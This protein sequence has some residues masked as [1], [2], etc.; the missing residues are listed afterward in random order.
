MVNQ[1]FEGF[2]RITLTGVEALGY[3]G[4]LTSERENGQPFI[5]DVVLHAEIR[6]AGRTDDLARTVDYSEVADVI[7]AAITGEPL[8]LIEA[9]AQRIAE[10]IFALESATR[11]NVSLVEVT[12]HK[13]QAPINVPFSDVSV[14]IVRVR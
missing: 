8:N 1:G 2:D 13:P 9:L 12:V 14:T 3:H 5:V 4:V 10:S 7:V 6:E 11:T